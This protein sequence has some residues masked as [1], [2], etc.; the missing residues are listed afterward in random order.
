LGAFAVLAIAVVTTAALCTCAAELAPCSVRCG[1]GADPC[2]SGLMCGDDRYCHERSTDTCAEVDLA[3]A[4]LTGADL[5]GVDLSGLDVAGVDLTGIDGKAP[6]IAAFA[7]E[8]SGTPESLYGV[9]GSSPSDVYVVG[10]NATIRHSIGDGNWTAQTAPIDATEIVT[11]VWGT[12]GVVYVVTNAGKILHSAGNGSWTMDTSVSSVLRCVWGTSA[13]DVYAA[14]YDGTVLHSTGDHVWHPQTFGNL[15]SIYFISGT[16]PTNLFAGGFFGSAR[17]SDG[18][19][20]WA[21]QS[22]ST[23]FSGNGAWSDGTDIWIVGNDAQVVR[24]SGNDVWTYS[25]TNP[26]GNGV[27]NGIWGPSKDLVYVAG[28]ALLYTTPSTDWTELPVTVTNTLRS[29]YGFSNGEVYAVGNG[30]TIFHGK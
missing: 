27:L 3:G 7:P 11:S 28:Y 2:P 15:E 6:I 24:S 30:G 16:S 12:S 26:F 14:G 13:S 25:A 19:G 18:S 1:T 22:L 4:D 9:W 20:T 23:Q 5:T 21:A 10:T 8:T 17:H 29:I